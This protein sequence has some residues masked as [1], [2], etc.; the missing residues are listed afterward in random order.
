MGVLM[1]DA[2]QMWLMSTI[3][4]SN[5][6]LCRE[7]HESIATHAR[8]HTHSLSLSLTLPCSA[9]QIFVLAHTFSSVP[10]TQFVL[11]HIVYTSIPRAVSTDD[12]M[13]AAAESEGIDKFGFG[14]GKM[15]ALQRAI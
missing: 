14:E 10:L 6:H 9:T 13:A 2:W 11:E 4:Q 8:T 5:S 3:E 15:N 7:L 1:G 12:M